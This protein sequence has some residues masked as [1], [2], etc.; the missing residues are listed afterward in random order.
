MPETP[1]LHVCHIDQG[2]PKFHACRRAEEALVAAGVEHD[3][4]VFDKN[5]PFGLFSSGKRPELKAMSGQEKLPVLE[6][7]DGS[8][9]NGSGAIVAWA[10]ENA[11]RA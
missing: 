8:T 7:P 4:R 9:V 3:K 11:G 1:T 10:K 2:G 6:L 5:K